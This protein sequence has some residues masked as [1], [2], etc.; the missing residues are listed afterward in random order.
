VRTH[1]LEMTL[2]ALGLSGMLETI[3]ARLAQ[4]HAGQL[5]QV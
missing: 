4:A 5:G 1:Q 3:E 2:P